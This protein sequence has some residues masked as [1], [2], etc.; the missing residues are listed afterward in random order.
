M[1]GLDKTHLWYSMSFSQRLQA[2]RKERGVTQKTLGEMV[3]VHTTQIQR[4]ESGETQPSLTAL[5][6]L[7]VALNVSAD[8]LVFDSEERDPP[9]DWRLQFEALSSF[10]E[11]ETKVA[12]AVIDGLILRHTANRFS[13][14]G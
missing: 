10:D 11:E 2:L 5:R 12:K 3:G 6:K 7:A 1:S 13:K 4:Y 14:A 9:D 8:A